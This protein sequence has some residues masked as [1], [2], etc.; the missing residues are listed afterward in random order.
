MKR[1]LLIVICALTI[2]GCNYHIDPRTQGRQPREYDSFDGRV[3]GAVFQGNV[4]RGGRPA[5][6]PMAVLVRSEDRQKEVIEKMLGHYE[7]LISED[8]RRAGEASDWLGKFLKEHQGIAP[9]SELAI[10]N[11]I[12]SLQKQRE[13]AVERL[14]AEE[15]SGVKTVIEEGIKK[16]DEQIE[17]FKLYQAERPALEKEYKKRT[18]VINDA[19]E[20]IRQWSSRYERIANTLKWVK[21]TQGDADPETNLQLKSVAEILNHKDEPTRITTIHWFVDLGGPDAEQ[22]LP[23]LMKIATDRT[24]SEIIRNAALVAV[25]KIE[26]Q[27]RQSSGQ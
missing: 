8:S 26:T 6:D 18:E 27:P 15:K 3:Q 7:R 2:A 16:V 5:T 25:E 14:A 9:D 12:H 21:Q 4:S 1:L 13:R 22:V 23:R 11:S 17:K 20:R 10:E 19:N 24:E